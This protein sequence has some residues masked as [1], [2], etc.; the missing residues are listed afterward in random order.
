MIADSTPSAGICTPMACCRCRLGVLGGAG[1][2]AFSA[3]PMWSAAWRC[4]ARPRHPRGH[5]RHP[6][7]FVSA[8]ASAALTVVTLWPA[9]AGS[10]PQTIG[11]AQDASP[12]TRLWRPVADNQGRLRAC[13]GGRSRSA[14]ALRVQPATTDDHGGW[15]RWSAARPADGRHRAIGEPCRPHGRGGRVQA[16]NGE[17]HHRQ[18]T[19]FALP[20]ACTKVADPS[21]RSSVAGRSRPCRFRE[22]H[23]GGHGSGR[24][25]QQPSFGL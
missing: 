11:A 4:S 9:G 24:D 23:V 15:R 18:G 8:I 14:G 21:A 16:G 17:R 25:V 3:L 7:S 5:R 1:C 20:T 19:V 2:C 22:D 10:V 13:C 12:A 6:A